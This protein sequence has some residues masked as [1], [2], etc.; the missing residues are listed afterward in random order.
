VAYKET[1]VCDRCGHTDKASFHDGDL[2]IFM[3]GSRIEVEWD[4]EA[5]GESNIERDLCSTCTDSLQAWLRGPKRD[6]RG[7]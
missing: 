1:I 4:P 7:G 3:A 6:P 5:G 2:S